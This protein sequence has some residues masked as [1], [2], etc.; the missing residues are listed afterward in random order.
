MLVPSGLG[1]RGRGGGGCD[2]AAQGLGRTRFGF[3]PLRPSWGGMAHDPWP[4]LVQYTSNL[5]ELVVTIGQSS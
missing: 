3:R 5:Y 2:D 4:V 1:G